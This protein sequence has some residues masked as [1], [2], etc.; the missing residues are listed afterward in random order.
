MKMIEARSLELGQIIG[1]EHA[2]G[3]TIDRYLGIKDLNSVL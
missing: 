2:E 1:V 3:F